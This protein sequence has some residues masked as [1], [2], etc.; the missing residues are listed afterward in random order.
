M[1]KYNL[2]TKVMYEYSETEELTHFSDSSADFKTCSTF[3]QECE[4][5]VLAFGK[6]EMIPAHSTA[7]HTS[8]SVHT[9]ISQ[10]CSSI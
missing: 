2:Q 6:Q 4:H 3:A 9:K 10:N 8:T 5:T 7:S 1:A